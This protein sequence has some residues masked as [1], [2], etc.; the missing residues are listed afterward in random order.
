MPM[1]AGHRAL[2][3]EASVNRREERFALAASGASETGAKL[4]GMAVTAQK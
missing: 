4:S 3:P 1:P 2:S